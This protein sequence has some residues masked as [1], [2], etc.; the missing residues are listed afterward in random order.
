MFRLKLYFCSFI[1]LYLLFSSQ[2]VIAVSTPSFSDL[3]PAATRMGAFSG[4]PPAAPV[5][6]DQALLGYIF[7]TVEVTP[8]PAYSGKPLNILVGLSL[9]GRILGIHLLEH[10]EPILVVGISE[11]QLNQFIA[12]YQGISIF[13]RVRVGAE[14]SED[15]VGIDAISGAT[16]T[17]M[18]ANASIINSA[19]KVA[20]SVGI[21]EGGVAQGTPHQEEQRKTEAARAELTRSAEDT[22]E[23]ESPW[24]SIWQ[25]RIVEII[26]LVTSLVVLTGIMLFQD[27]IVRHPRQYTWLHNGFLIFTV[28]FIGGYALAQL[29]VVNVLTFVHALFHDFNWQ[30]FALDPLIFILWAF[31]ALTLLLWGRGV[32]CGWLC[33]FGA[34]QELINKTARY[35]GIRQWELPDI[36]HERLWALKYV[37]L[38]VL[39]GISLQSVAEAERYAE[40]EPF[41]TVVLLHF[42]REWPF[43][44]YAAGLLLLSIVNRK[45]YCK[46]LCPLAAALVIPAQNRIFDWVRRRT[47]CGKPCQICNNECEVRAIAPTGEINK[48]ECHYCLD[49]QVTYWNEHKCPPLVQLRKRR[50][51]RAM[52]R[53]VALESVVLKNKNHDHDDTDAVLRD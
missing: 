34:L 13:D 40:V 14:T 35:F 36:V 50:E 48:N 6:E 46:Y 49:C 42:Q 5:Y 44:L 7:R 51:R 52:T 11:Q 4:D 47:E 39:F 20:Q 9:E 28:V 32:Y 29:S 1:G 43:V 25:G 10:Q 33:P 30:T 17:V 15:S 31:V 22:I 53:K 2:L 18:V 45:F 3:F 37:I 23:F 24:A 41:K 38:V 19:R 8:I 21:R 27:W 26:I 12:Q 16:I